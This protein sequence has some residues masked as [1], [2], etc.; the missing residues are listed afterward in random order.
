[1]TD[2]FTLEQLRRCTDAKG[3]RLSR[4]GAQGLHLSFLTVPL[5]A[6]LFTQ[7]TRQEAFHA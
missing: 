3:A 7:Q 6:R 4:I 2:V 1:M 5:A